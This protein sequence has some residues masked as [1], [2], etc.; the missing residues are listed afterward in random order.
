MYSKE[1]SKKLRI[2][3]WN[4]FG[5]LSKK[6]RKKQA[7]V[8]YNTKVKNLS[9]KFVAEQKYSSVVMDIEYKSNKKR[10]KFY[11]NMLSLQTVF[12]TEFDDK[13]I[14]NKDFYIDGEKEVSRI[15]I[16][17]KNVSIYKK[18]DW[19]TIFEFLFDNMNK[20]ENIFLEYKDIIK[21]FVEN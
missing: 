14:W 10:H 12:N 15:H 20:L 2:E 4:T 19:P 9:L 16:D 1:E 8:L 21:E 13:L 17:L 18:E 5:S 11:E 6:K 7:W 3:F